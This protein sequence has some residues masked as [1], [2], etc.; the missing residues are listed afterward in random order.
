MTGRRVNPRP[1][2]APDP[3]APPTPIDWQRWN[4]AL[5]QVYLLADSRIAEAAQAID[6]NPGDN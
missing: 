6:G 4:D 5:D 1:G 2:E 3:P